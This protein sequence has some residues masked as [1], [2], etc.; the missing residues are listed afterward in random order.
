MSK[1]KNRVGDLPSSYRACD[2][3][4]LSTLAAV[5]AASV[6]DDTAFGGNGE[7]P[8]T[9][10]IASRAGVLLGTRLNEELTGVKALLFDR[11][12][13]VFP[14]STSVNPGFQGMGIGTM[15]AERTREISVHDGSGMFYTLASP[16]NGPQLNSYLNKMGFQA[17]DFY[18]A[19]FTG[20]ADYGVGVDRLLITKDFISGGGG[21]KRQWILNSLFLWMIRMVYLMLFLEALW[22]IH[23][24]V[25]RVIQ[26]ITLVL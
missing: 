26:I 25:A 2:V 14:L 13:R 12:K 17:S 21:H 8:H 10:F 11:D 19:Y 22:L 5:F 16:R 15:M 3:E 7:T 24:C 9:M 4:H 20:F 1:V 23:F 6:V 18:P